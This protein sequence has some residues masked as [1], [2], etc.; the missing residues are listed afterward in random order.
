MLKFKAT[1]LKLSPLSSNSIERSLMEIPVLSGKDVG[2]NEL[3]DL[4]E[5]NFTSFSGVIDAAS[6]NMLFMDLI[7][8]SAF[9][10]AFSMILSKPKKETL[11]F[12]CFPPSPVLPTFSSA[13]CIPTASR[14]LLI[15]LVIA[16]FS[17]SKT[18]CF[19][20]IAVS[21]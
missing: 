9:S 4:P 8:L 2:K 16:C 20:T 1:L 5:K 13:I 15:A 19:A 21:L 10:S 6:G 14:Y 17:S 18:V 12:A 11:P 7:F 3:S